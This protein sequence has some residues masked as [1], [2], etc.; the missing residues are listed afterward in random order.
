M[1]GVYSPDRPAS[2]VARWLGVKDLEPPITDQEYGL[3]ERLRALLPHAPPDIAARIICPSGVNRRTRGAVRK[4]V[5]D[6]GLGHLLQVLELAKTH[7][8]VEERKREQERKAGEAVAEE[9]RLQT[10]LAEV[11]KFHD[12]QLNELKLHFGQFQ[13]LIGA[14]SIGEATLR[15]AQ[16][17]QSDWTKNARSLNMNLATQGGGNSAMIFGMLA[18]AEN[19]MRDRS[20]AR[21]VADGLSRFVIKRS[22]VLMTDAERAA[23]RMG[24]VL[25]VLGRITPDEFLRIA[26]PIAWNGGECAYDFD[27]GAEY[28]VRAASLEVV[29]QLIAASLGTSAGAREQVNQAV[30]NALAPESGLPD[31]QRQ[32]IERY[33]FSGNRWMSEAE[34]QRADARGD[35][36]ASAL[37]IGGFPDGTA[38]FTYDKRE[39]LVTIA[40]SGSGKT[41]AHVLR[42]LLYMTAPAVVLDVKGEMHEQ[43]RKWREDNVGPTYVFKPTDPE[44]SLRYNPIDEIRTDPDF[45]WDDARRLADFLM[46][47]GLVPKFEYWET[48]ARDMI[49]LALLDVA[50]NEEA[51]HRNMA[52]VLDRIWTSG[53]EEILEWCE[54]LEDSGNPQL[55][56]G[57]SALKGL[58][59]K[60]R[61]SVFDTA[62]TWLEVWMS[63]A[64]RKIS[65]ESNFDPGALREQNATLYLAVNLEDIKKFASVLRVLIGEA[66]IKVYRGKPE[67]DA[68]TITFFLDE[69]VRLGRLD[70]IEESLDVGRGYGVRLWL[71]CQNYGQLKTTYPNA[72]GMI[73][74]CAVRSYMNPDEDTARWLSENLGMRQG[75]LDGN[76][77]P[78]VEHHVLTGPE[79]VDQMV[80]FSRGAPPA[81][82]NKLPAYGDPE[83][84]AKVDGSWAKP[85]A[86]AETFGPASKPEPQ[87][88][89]GQSPEMAQT[90]SAKADEAP[91][92]QADAP[93]QSI[94]WDAIRASAPLAPPASTTSRQGSLNWRT[95]AAVAI[96]ALALLGAIVWL[97][98]QASEMQ[99]LRVDNVSLAMARDAAVGSRDAL[100]RE[101][102]GFT[103]TLGAAERD[104]DF[105]R[106]NVI[107][108]EAD[109]R[110]EVN[111]HA[112]TRQQLANVQQ[113]LENARSAMKNAPQPNVTP[114]YVPQSVPAP[115]PAP[116]PP[117]RFPTSPQVRVTDCDLLAANPNDRRRA[118][119]EL[120][121]KWL[122]LK[123]NT[124]AAIEACD[125]AIAENPSELRFVYQRA[126]ALDAAG[127]EAAW[128]LF[129]QLLRAG[130]PS[131][132]DNKGQF[133]ARRNRWQ[134]AEPYFRDGVTLD[135]PDAMIS[136][137]DAIREQRLRARNLG[138]ADALYDRAASLGHKGAQADVAK[139]QA[140]GAVV[141]QI[142]EIIFGNPPAR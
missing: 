88:A 91:A 54:R 138:E 56:L 61:E 21:G 106:S 98:V 40:P 10:R 45:A 43:T 90:G 64:I 69:L 4:L 141:K 110:R 129:D 28:R 38:E 8:E 16:Q 47:P 65:A 134:E 102:A 108:A 112:V 109:L 27:A 15:I 118:S 42:N 116:Y 119:P 68:S 57:A 82:L 125:R 131:A 72:Q 133:Y 103:Q 17:S 136:L 58:D 92:G 1:Q 7:A 20:Q 6:P 9:R 142:G 73:S 67:T 71:F 13:H 63:P 53:D 49:T 128:P 111:A 24:D 12:N 66:L 25:V 126:R 101:K 80:V 77:K 124:A 99:S 93:S 37:R 44:A 70:V 87:G 117:A 113:E 79:F 36:S 50:L 122:D 62:R 96:L 139:R 115:A 120:G 94:D 39:S 135:D 51:G 59:K 85:E 83:C 29:K 35:L 31:R 2:R 81:R 127:N 78:L 48:R 46:I 140:A 60:P 41:Q 95:A 100:A 107:R 130:Y 23:L 52:G 18:G 137:A 55:V 74:N 123:R 105:A 121:V 89:A 22:L 3:L 30:R 75:L 26:V 33:L 32:I 84:R 5:S 86:A 114:Q 76:R 104:R 19:N 11:D 132:F 14:T 34:G 97:G